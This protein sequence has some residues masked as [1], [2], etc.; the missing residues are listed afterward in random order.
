VSNTVQGYVRTS[1]ALLQSRNY[2]DL[3]ALNVVGTSMNRANVNGAGINNGDFVIADSSRRSPRN[4]DYV[5]AV[6]DELANLKRFHF[7]QANNQ[8]VLISESSE[9]YLP[10]FVHP[11]DSNEGLISG[12]VVQVMRRPV[13]SPTLENSL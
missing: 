11:E 7:D 5:I 4:G 12:T 8:V 9:D 10:I 3:F 1:S 2:K 6:V 13:I